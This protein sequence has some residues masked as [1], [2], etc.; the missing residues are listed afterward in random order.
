MYSGSKAM[1]RAPSRASKRPKR[2][3]V[4]AR[5]TATR[6]AVITAAAQ[7]LGR[8]GYA[9][10]STNH[11]AQRAG[12]SIGT[13]YEYFPN[14]QAIVHAV[15]EAHI[16]AGEA[17]LA[18]RAAELV[19]HAPQAPLRELVA[20]W[21]D[22]ML[23]LHADDPR[24]HRVLFSEV[25]RTRALDARVA[26]LEAQVSRVIEALLRAHPQ[27]RVRSCALSAQLVVATIEALTHR[28]VID[29]AGS[30]VPKAAL[31][32]ELI[33]MVAGYLGGP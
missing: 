8:R 1:P 17:L 12:V 3:P 15:L 28:W 20:H 19:P 32:S 33:D 30:P 14:K 13:V 22:V 10:F 24:L 26:Q 7:L 9:E 31:R 21:V 11:V 18:A 23:D 25:P 6:S 2:K 29:A 4:Q 5:S 16:A 27:A